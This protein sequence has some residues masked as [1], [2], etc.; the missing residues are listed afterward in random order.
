MITLRPRRSLVTS[1]GLQVAMFVL[2]LVLAIAMLGSDAPSRIALIAGTFLLLVA[3]GWALLRLRATMVT[4]GPDGFVEVGFLGR[5]RVVAAQDI[6]RIVRLRTY[7]GPSL[8]TQ[9]QLFVVGHDG[10]CLMRLRGS[11]WDAVCMDSVACAV[12]VP[13]EVRE[14]PV[15]FAELRR[16]EPELLYWW[17]RAT[18]RVDPAAE[19]V[20]A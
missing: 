2:P 20:D 14:E 5:I 19:R 6:E 10:R 17:E 11:F 8:E 13:E 16:S 12:D 1:I 9:D 18:N 3:C 7:R 4:V 15:T